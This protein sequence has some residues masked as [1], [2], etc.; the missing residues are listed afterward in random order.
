MS[1]KSSED[2]HRGGLAIR[3]TVCSARRPIARE[4]RRTRCGHLRPPHPTVVSRIER[5]TVLALPV[6]VPSK[7]RVRRIALSPVGGP[8]ATG[9]ALLGMA[10]EE[11]GQLGGAPAAPG[12]ASGSYLHG[13][14]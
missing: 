13:E 11:L 9:P 2:C 14:G 1:L 7:L 10:L 4:P 3:V 6:T 12:D 5:S 8:R